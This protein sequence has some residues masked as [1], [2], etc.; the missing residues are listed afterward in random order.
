[1][2]IQAKY[3]NKIEELVEAGHC[4]FFGYREWELEGGRRYQR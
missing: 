2:E 1:M 4:V 3:W